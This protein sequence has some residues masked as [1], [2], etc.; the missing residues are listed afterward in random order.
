MF[1]I[2]ERIKKY[3][4]LRYEQLKKHGKKACL[5]P[6]SQGEQLSL[7]R[8]TYFNFVYP[9]IKEV[10]RGLGKGAEYRTKYLTTP[11]HR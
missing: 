9:S 2:K 5:Q 7:R 3:K 1:L 6:C 11:P 8:K 4:V 10:F